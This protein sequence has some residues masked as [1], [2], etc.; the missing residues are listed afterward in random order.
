MQSK[1]YKAYNAAPKSGILVQ[2]CMIK[3]IGTT[4]LSGKASSQPVSSSLH[5]VTSKLSM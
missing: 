2:C 5:N 3:K 1:I 4:L